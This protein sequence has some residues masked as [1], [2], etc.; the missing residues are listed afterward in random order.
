MTVQLAK[1]WS[2]DLHDRGILAVFRSLQEVDTFVDQNKDRFELSE[3]QLIC[4]DYGED[5]FEESTL[6]VYYAV[7]SSCCFSD[8]VKGEMMYDPKGDIWLDLYIDNISNHDTHTEDVIEGFYV[9]EIAATEIEGI[10]DVNIVYTDGERSSM[11]N[12]IYDNKIGQPIAFE[13]MESLA[14]FIRAYEYKQFDMEY[15]RS[16]QAMMKSF[17]DNGYMYSVT[18]E[19]SEKG[20]DGIEI[21]PQNL[22]RGVGDDGYRYL[23]EKDGTAY[24]VT[25][26]NLQPWGSFDEEDTIYEYCF[27]KFGYMLRDCA[28]SE[29]QSDSL[30]TIYRYNPYNTQTVFYR[31]LI[32]RSYY[33]D[34]RTVDAVDTENIAQFIQSLSFEKVLLHTNT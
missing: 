5:Y 29:I 2:R 7:G 16:Y 18:S 33:V 26:Y 9:I 28:K 13:S 1:T 3:F 24:L 14:D 32:D 11:V 10:D 19:G 27:N 6:L 31:A 21:F 12:F 22:S 8:I 17:L 4:D 20:S 15:R 23:F 34:V 30:Q 25:V